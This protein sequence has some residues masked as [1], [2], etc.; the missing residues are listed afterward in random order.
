MSKTDR[1]IAK[2]P[3]AGEEKGINLTQHTHDVYRA[4][5]DIVAATI[6]DPVNNKLAELFKINDFNKLKQYYYLSCLVHD[7]GKANSE[8]VGGMAGTFEKQNIRHEHISAYI[9][10]KYRQWFLDAG[11][12][13]YYLIAAALGHHLKSPKQT[14]EN[15]PTLGETR[16]QGRDITIYLESIDIKN[17]FRLLAKEMRINSIPYLKEEIISNGFDVSEILEGCSNLDKRFVFA[18]KA[19]LVWADTFGSAVFED[20]GPVSGRHKVISKNRTKEIFAIL[21]KSKVDFEKFFID[22]RGDKI[23]TGLQRSISRRANARRL[24]II[25]NCGSGKT[26]AEFYWAR[27]LFNRGTINRLMH[28][29]PTKSLVNE[30]YKKYI[31]KHSESTLLH[32]QRVFALK[33]MSANDKD[34]E[35]INTDILHNMR[36]DLY[37]ATP[38]QILRSLHFNRKSIMYLMLLVGS[39]VVFDEIHSYDRNMM[40]FF[41]DFCETFDVPIVAMTATL[42]P[43]LKK[44]LNACGFGKPS[45]ATS[46]DHKRYEFN[47][48]DDMD[49]NKL[50]N[51]LTNNFNTALIITNT[52]NRCRIM[53]QYVKQIVDCQVITFHSRFTYRDRMAIHDSI[54]NEGK[55]VIVATQVMELGVDLSADLFISENCPMD[56]L[57]QRLGRVNRNQ[58]STSVAKCFMYSPAD[59]KPYEEKE[60]EYTKQAVQ[61]ISKMSYE[62]LRVLLESMPME[63]V[64]SQE[65]YAFS[66]NPAYTYSRE[67]KFRMETVPS[68]ACVVYE[69]MDEIIT[70]GRNGK[71]LLDEFFIPIP[72]YD[73]KNNTKR[74]PSTFNQKLD[75][76]LSKQFLVHKGHYDEWGYR[77][78]REPTLF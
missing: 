67:E 53:S 26:L 75:K 9:I 3:L 48:C 43:Q 49:Y 76:M 31:S 18:L 58:H 10:F 33:Y 2:S 68:T 61:S 63:E 44:Q 28:I 77:D 37:S 30:Y 40:R 39:A 6:D 65:V 15:Y 11:I 4:A 17:I 36:N 16:E 7:L 62:D 14:N 72:I 29:T 19:M 54:Y 78:G 46:S 8:F 50:K 34:D 41:R 25:A 73:L 57:I 13:P 12:N 69:D 70:K 59:I 52:V 21:N 47:Y 20:P 32:G 35:K 42:T 24:A 71:L 1:I 51:I 27:K 60:L 22:V 38:D 55:K 56:S 66:E 45:S 74:F 23:P 64:S 5:K